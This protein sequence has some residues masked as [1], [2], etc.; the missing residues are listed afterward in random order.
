MDFLIIPPK[1]NFHSLLHAYN[2]DREVL[3][4]HRSA[5]SDPNEVYKG[6]IMIFLYLLGITLSQNF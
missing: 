6:F 1:N 5:V 3:R 2:I 4:T